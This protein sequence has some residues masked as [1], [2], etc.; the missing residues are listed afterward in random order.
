ML[1]QFFKQRHEMSGQVLDGRRLEEIRA[2]RESPDP[3]FT[4][5]AKVQLK[6]KTRRARRQVMPG[7]LQARQHQRML[8][9]VLQGKRRLEKRMAA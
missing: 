6:I 2:V 8:R 9:R 5:P 4:F 7:Y 3:R 1:N